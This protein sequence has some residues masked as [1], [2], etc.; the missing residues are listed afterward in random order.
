LGLN[1]IPNGVTFDKLS[2]CGDGLCNA[3]ESSVGVAWELF[4]KFFYE[5]VVRFND[6]GT[7]GGEKLSFRF[8]C[9]L[10]EDFDFF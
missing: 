5:F 9:L 8:G 1:F 10:D 3:D 7:S 6:I 4:D 2:I